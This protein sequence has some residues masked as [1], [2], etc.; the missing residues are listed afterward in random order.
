MESFISA[1]K[2][3]KTVYGV[4]L[5]LKQLLQ[6]LPLFIE[7]RKKLCGAQKLTIYIDESKI[8]EKFDLKANNIIQVVA[9]KHW[10]YDVVDLNDMYY[11]LKY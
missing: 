11:E 7:K 10:H 2:N 1:S 9:L 8:R 3:L 5:D 6:K 4:I